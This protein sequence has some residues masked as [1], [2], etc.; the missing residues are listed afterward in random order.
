MLNIYDSEYLERREK[1]NQLKEKM[2][3]LMPVVELMKMRCSPN[4]LREL[5]RNQQLR[6][7]GYSNEDIAQMCPPEKLDNEEIME[8]MMEEERKEYRRLKKQ[9]PNYKN[10]SKPGTF[11]IIITFEIEPAV[12]DEKQPFKLNL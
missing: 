7:M 1:E 12:I 8:T 3:K 5:E 2:Q 10:E 4:S 11:D 9:Y 6:I